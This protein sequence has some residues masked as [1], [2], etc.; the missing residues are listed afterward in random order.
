M[1]KFKGLT[2]DHPRGYD[3]LA[4]AARRVPDLIHWDKQPLEGFESTPIEDICARYDIVVLDHPH[5]GDAIA[6]DCLVPLNE[7]IAPE[8]LAP[9]RA[10]TIGPC[11]HSY[12]MD[13]C[14][15]ALP[16]DAA[17]QVSAGRMDLMAEPMPSDWLEV[18]RI[19]SVENG[20]TLSLAGPHAFLTLLSLCATAKD[21]F[22]PV[23][24]EFLQP[25]HDD[26]VA[27]FCELLRRSHPIG[28]AR[29]PIGILTAMAA[30]EGPTYCPLIFGY[31][32]YASAARPITFC[33]A[34]RATLAGVPRAVL[35][36]TG[37]AI[38]KRCS[39]DLA[40]VD[41]LVWLLSSEVQTELLPAHNGQPSSE[42]AWSSPA[43][44]QA[45]NDFYI[46]TLRTLCNAFVRPR[47]PGFV[48]AQNRAAAW[49]R[50]RLDEDCPAP[51]VIR[52]RIN[53][54]LAER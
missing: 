36:G 17:A 29:N 42:E 15:W 32:L 4:W 38:T 39:P 16:L 20:F 45:S 9:I 10:R 51:S 52:A 8:T 28:A 46:N 37:I 12:V 11:F 22:G 49:L 50:D 27:L 48:V 44:N 23:E 43:L 1:S 31:V 41:H 21:G 2:W 14:V 18:E 53:Q 3:G 25:H 7:V 30:G 34:P 19:A 47:T 33:D 5:L 35:G 13:S 26:A 40:L 54:L 24:Q 6:A